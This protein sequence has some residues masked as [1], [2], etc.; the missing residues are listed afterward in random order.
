M[1]PDEV[2]AIVREELANDHGTLFDE[3]VDAEVANEMAALNAIMS[4]E[5][6]RPLTL[7]V[8]AGVGDIEEHNRYF[9]LA[10]Y[11]EPGEFE[12]DELRKHHAE[13]V[14]LAALFGEA[15]CS[16]TEGR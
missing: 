3:A 10:E 9:H 5:D 16:A 1:T 14:R 13:L 15:I 4:S 8:Y 2:R 12:L 7:C 6:P 11:L